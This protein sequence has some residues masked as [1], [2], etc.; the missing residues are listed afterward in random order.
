MLRK[1]RAET[2]VS[3]TLSE[4]ESQ[5][6]SLSR[7]CLI[8]REDLKASVDGQLGWWREQAVTRH[9]AHCVECREEKEVM[10]EFSERLRQNEFQQNGFQP[11]NLEQKSGR[12]KFG[13]GGFENADVLDPALRARILAAVPN[14]PPSLPGRDSTSRP[15][16]L[17]LYLVGAAASSILLAVVLFPIFSAS[18][19]SATNDRIASS[20]PEGQT[21]AS[22]IPQP[23]GRAANAGGASNRS[24]SSES[25]SGKSFGSEVKSKAPVIGYVD[26]AAPNSAPGPIAHRSASSVSSAKQNPGAGS[27]FR[28]VQDSA[29]PEE[30]TSKKQRLTEDDGAAVSVVVANVEQGAASVEQTVRQVGG[31]IVLSALTTQSDKT[32]FAKLTVKIPASQRAAF[33]R[34]VAQYAANKASSSVPG[35]LVHS[36]EPAPAIVPAS[37]PADTSKEPGMVAVTIQLTGTKK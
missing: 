8:V 13:R 23:A 20:A 6:S 15:R 24:D 7:D 34:Q 11:G 25:A 17:P 27:S 21:T 33:M 16:R 35:K 9:I 28:S 31:S 3:D 14:T 1:Q 19:Q 10:R 5:V 26:R 32:E 22:A 12:E 30:K 18:R 2:R 4:Q 36:S 37:P 29:P